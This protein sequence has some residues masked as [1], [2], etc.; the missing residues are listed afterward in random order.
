M[1]DTHSLLILLVLALVT[2]LVRFLPFLLFGNGKKM[3]DT[4]LRLG[5]SLPF[6]AMGMLV[7]YCLKDVDL[8][9]APYGAAEG[10]AC[11]V[12]GLVHI[13]KRN[14]VLSILVGTAVYT[15]LI[16]LVF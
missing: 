14:T 13:R 12:T 7:V 2:A 3:P 15:L 16:R 10:I 6:A 1:K 4:V 5:R 8:T 9:A 11:L